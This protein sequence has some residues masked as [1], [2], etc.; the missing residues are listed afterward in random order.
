MFNESTIL[1]VYLTV[2][3]I[4]FFEILGAEA[5]DLVKLTASAG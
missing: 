5:R 2:C 3:E 4:E 1:S